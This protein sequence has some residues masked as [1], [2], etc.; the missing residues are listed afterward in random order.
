M[1]AAA[2]FLPAAI[3]TIRRSF[4]NLLNAQQIE[5]V[6]SPALLVFDRASNKS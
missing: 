4:M 2:L 3:Q 6:I 1:R 5:T